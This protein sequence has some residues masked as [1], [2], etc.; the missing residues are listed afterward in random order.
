MAFARRT[1]RRDWRWCR[2]NLGR[3]YVKPSR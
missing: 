3:L 2:H 1:A